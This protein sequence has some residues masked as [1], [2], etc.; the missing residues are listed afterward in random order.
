MFFGHGAG[1]QYLPSQQLR[2]RQ[3][4][5]ACLLAGCSLGRLARQGLYSP[6][7]PI[8]AYILAGTTKF[9]KKL[10]PARY[11]ASKI[12]LAPSFRHLDAQMMRYCEFNVQNDDGHNCN[13]AAL[14]LFL[15]L[16]TMKPS[17]SNF[18]FGAGW[19]RV[20]LQRI[21]RPTPFV[22]PFLR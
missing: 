18:V 2:H 15:A 10:L 16:D 17:D 14:N 22:L 5:C 1:G 11:E 3:S 9:L 6:S 20:P 21:E 13:T 8:L 12:P 7:G 19:A 4:Q